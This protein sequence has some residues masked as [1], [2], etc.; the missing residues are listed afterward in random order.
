[1]VWE[2]GAV[3]QRVVRESGI[4]KVTLGQRPEGNEVVRAMQVGVR[5]ESSE[6]NKR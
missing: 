2:S 3:L 6:Q 1:M 4:E 5:E